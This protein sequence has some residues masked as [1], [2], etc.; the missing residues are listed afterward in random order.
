MVYSK[1]LDHLALRVTLKKFEPE[2]KRF[3]ERFMTD[4]ATALCRNDGKHSPHSD[5]Q[6]HDGWSHLRLSPWLH[7]PTETL[8]TVHVSNKGDGIRAM[9]C[10]QHRGTQPEIQRNNLEPM[11]NFV[12]GVPS[13]VIQVENNLDELQMRLFVE[14]MERATVSEILAY[15]MAGGPGAVYE[16]P[17]CLPYT[18]D[19]TNALINTV[20][21]VG[22]LQLKVQL[23][24]NIEAI[25]V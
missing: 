1:V 17:A 14:A 20:D 19:D 25:L 21:P 5:N 6:E 18:K 10:I 11:L 4:E 13:R 9:P 15:L 12:S 2:H 24:T 16:V 8:T 7:V 23:G 22:S 3:T